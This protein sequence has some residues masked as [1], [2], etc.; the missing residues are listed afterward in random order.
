MDVH[1]HVFLYHYSAGRQAVGAELLHVGNLPGPEEDLG[2]AKLE[3]V[4]ILKQ[5]QRS[6]MRFFKSHVDSL[7]H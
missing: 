2:A 5:L 4:F 1:A 3:L 6:S 7:H